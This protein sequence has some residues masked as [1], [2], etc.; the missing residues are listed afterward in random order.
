MREKQFGKNPEIPHE[1]SFCSSTVRMRKLWN[2]TVIPKSCMKG[3]VADFSSAN[4]IKA[5]KAIT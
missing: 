2:N 4:A 5:K 1:R 3:F